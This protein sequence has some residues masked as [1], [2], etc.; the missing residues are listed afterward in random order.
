VSFHVVFGDKFLVTAWEG[1]RHVFATDPLV[2][3]V[4]HFGLKILAA[5]LASKNLSVLVDPPDVDSK[6]LGGNPLITGL[7]VQLLLFLAT[8]SLFTDSI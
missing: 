2:L 1:A 6:G 7:A 5:V 4:A 3:A 8:S